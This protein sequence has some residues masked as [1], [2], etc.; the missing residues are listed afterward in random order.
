MLI[1][2]HQRRISYLRLSITDLCNFKCQYCLPDGYQCDDKPSFMNVDEIRRVTTAFAELGVWKVRITGGEPT[3]RKDFQQIAKTISQVPGIDRIAVTTNGFRLLNNA[4]HWRAVGINRLNVSVDSLNP[5]TFNEIT[6]HNRLP[7]ILK[8]IDQAMDLDFDQVKANVVL[9]KG[10][11]DDEKSLKDFFNWTKNKKIC[12]CFIEL[13]QTGENKEYFQRYHSSADNLRQHFLNTGWTP[14]KRTASA[15]PAI[16]YNHPD[17][18]GNVGI[19]AA[20]SPSFCEGCNRL[21]ISATGD[22]HL[23]LFGN[24]G[25]PLRQL[26]Q[27]DSQKE[28]LKQSILTHLDEKVPAHFLSDGNPGGTPHLASI[29]G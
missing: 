10:I 20:Y 19:I 13:M 16:V 15:G 14:S 28:E 25:I 9:H 21:R 29:G 23:C 5:A 7:D 11:N 3:V 27:A 22:L 2:P 17:H 8:G 1:D 18:T 12:V 6:G 24:N 4:H 26:L